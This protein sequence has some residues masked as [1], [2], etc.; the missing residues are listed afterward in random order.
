[1]IIII[2]IAILEVIIIIFINE[3]VIVVR[4]GMDQIEN[5]RKAGIVL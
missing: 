3:S 2:G 5:E 4:A 1:M